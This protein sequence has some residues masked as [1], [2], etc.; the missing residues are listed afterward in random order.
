[1]K[2]ATT[3]EGETK[4]AK[5]PTAM[6]LAADIKRAK[7]IL[8]HDDEMYSTI[9]GWCLRHG[10]T[11]QA[12]KYY[13][14][15]LALQ[16]NRCPNHSDEQFSKMLAHHE[17]KLK[18]RN[19]AEK[20]FE[21][22]VKRLREDPDPNAYAKA[23]RAGALKKP[24]INVP[25]YPV[26]Y[27]KEEFVKQFPVVFTSHVLRPLVDLAAANEKIDPTWMKRIGDG[28]RNEDVR[29]GIIMV[30]QRIYFG[31]KKR[32]EAIQNLLKDMD[33]PY[34]ELTRIPLPKVKREAPVRNKKVPEVKK[35]WKVGG[36]LKEKED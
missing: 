4:P 10:R 20:E 18:E 23:T 22:Q 28:L 35:W 9:I 8:Q 6:P 30:A 13:K 32:Y 34:Q 33:L 16:Y 5:P 24:S 29:A 21:E 14:Y 1:V 26:R 27:T 19:A 15:R 25:P 3:T 2:D 17:K 7:A 36:L 12:E 31:D 11:K